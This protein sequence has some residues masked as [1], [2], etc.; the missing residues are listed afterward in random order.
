M[1]FSVEAHGVVGQRRLDDVE[2][3]TLA[4]ADRRHV[5]LGEVLGKPLLN[6]RVDVPRLCHRDELRVAVDLGIKDLREG[7]QVRI[8]V[9]VLGELL[10]GRLVSHLVRVHVNEVIDIHRHVVESAVGVALKEQAWVPLRD[11]EAMLDEPVA[12]HLVPVPPRRPSAI[13]GLR[14]CPNET[15]PIVVVL[16]GRLRRPYVVDVLVSVEVGLWEVP[17]GPLSTLSSHQGKQRPQRCHLD[18][19]R[20]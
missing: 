19:R 8:A 18:R 13:E 7:P 4:V 16:S 12:Q 5:C 6:Q 9:E 14:Q 3:R 10:D 17:G 1:L 20:V 11:L 15:L 2:Q